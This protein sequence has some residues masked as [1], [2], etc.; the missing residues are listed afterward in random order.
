MKPKKWEVKSTKEIFKNPWAR[1]RED[2]V[3][4]ELNREL[5]FVVLELPFG[6]SVLPIDPEGNVYL[7]KQYRHGYGEITIET[8]GGKLDEGETPEQAARRETEEEIGV[9]PKKLIPLGTISGLTSNIHHT[10]YLFLAELDSVPEIS[11]SSDE[12]TLSLEKVSMQQA[13]YWAVDGTIVH[14]PAIAVILRA[15]E[16]LKL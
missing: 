7:I 12:E 2:I 1:L 10:E 4:D 8:P 14:G 5:N 3:K 6:S 13:I 15:K 11:F 16:Y 9:L